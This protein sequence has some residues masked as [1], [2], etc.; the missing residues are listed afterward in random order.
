MGGEDNRHEWEN[1]M[2][3]SRP[4]WIP[5]GN[6]SNITDLI[7][8]EKIPTTST[9]RKQISRLHYGEFVDFLTIRH[10]RL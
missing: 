9:C 10:F 8:P 5:E 1:Q 7:R 4:A 6:H 2:S 3:F